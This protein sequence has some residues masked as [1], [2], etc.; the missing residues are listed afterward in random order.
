MGDIELVRAY[1][2]EILII[3][4]GML[5]HQWHV[6]QTH[7]TIGDGAEKG[8]KTKASVPTGASATLHEANT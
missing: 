3:T 7:A 6:N 1:M 8:S 2:D 4:N 5:T